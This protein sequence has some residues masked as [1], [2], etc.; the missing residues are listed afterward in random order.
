[1]SRTVS[2]SQ[3]HV[4]EV[5]RAVE[6]GGVVVFPTDTVYGIGCSPYDRAA[7]ERIYRIKQRDGRKPLPVLAHSISELEAV[8]EFSGT[9]KRIAQKFWPGQVTL[10]LGLTD[11]KIGEA[12]GITGKIAV[13]VPGG[14]CVSA[15]LQRCGLLVG[16]SANLSGE[17]PITDPELVVQRVR[18]YDILVDGGAIVSRGESTIVD[19][20]SADI[21]ILRE[22]AIRQ[23]EILDAL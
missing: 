9:A 23:Q 14:A 12:L 6:G 16:T 11:G 13:R 7:V 18:G 22:G 19:A 21:R 10:L 8:A 17:E 15:I 5:G 20:T 3:K 2:C 1:M 4:E